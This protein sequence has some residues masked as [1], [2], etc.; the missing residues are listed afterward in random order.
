[1]GLTYLS[2]LLIHLYQYFHFFIFLTHLIIIIH[3]LDNHN[4]LVCIFW[5]KDFYHFK[6]LIFYL[7]FNISWLLSFQL[8][9]AE[10][11]ARLYIQSIIL[12]KK[13]AHQNKSTQQ[14]CPHRM[15]DHLV[16]FVDLFFSFF[17]T[18]Q[19]RLLSLP[20]FHNFESMKDNRLCPRRWC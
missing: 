2:G 8:I 18:T 17:L 11:Y 5:E 16:I 6:L 15:Y 13:N 4:L 19:Q 1:M 20:V 10:I 9:P 3:L 14:A 7:I 12:K